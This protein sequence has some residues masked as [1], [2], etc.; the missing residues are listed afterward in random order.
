M[1]KKTQGY[2]Y[3]ES[4]N[5]WR[6]TARYLK[7]LV[8]LVR[9][10]GDQIVRVHYFSNDRIPTNI[11]TGVNAVWMR[12]ELSDDE[13]MTRALEARDVEQRIYLPAHI[14]RADVVYVL[15]ENDD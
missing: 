2:W 9:A 13:I 14:M 11:V 1:N 5:G 7:R 15:T 10:Q 3:L 12:P 4:D 6:G 8:N